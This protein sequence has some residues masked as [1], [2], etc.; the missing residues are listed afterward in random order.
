[1]LVGE[2]WTISAGTPN[3]VAI[4]RMPDNHSCEMILV[5][6]TALHVYPPYFYSFLL[7][8]TVLL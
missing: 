5:L 8:L 3:L 1:M 4:V 6:I 7:I 2:E